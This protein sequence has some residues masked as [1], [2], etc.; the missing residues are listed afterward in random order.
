MPGLAHA[1]CGAGRV[2]GAILAEQQHPE[3]PHSRDR[4]QLR[5]ESEAR[6]AGP[7]VFHEHLIAG[8]CCGQLGDGP[9]ENLV[10]AFQT[11]RR[12]LCGC[13]PASLVAMVWID[14]KEVAKQHLANATAALARA[15]ADP[16]VS[17]DVVEALAELRGMSVALA[18]MAG[19]GIFDEE[20]RSR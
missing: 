14:Q 20:P 1:Q 3:A 12:V 17:R 13:C 15:D 19:V 11:S 7:G 6:P 9:R 4:G 10:H 8:A 16:A 5:C 2:K 18:K